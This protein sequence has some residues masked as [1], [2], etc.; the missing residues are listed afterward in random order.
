MSNLMIWPVGPPGFMAGITLQFETETSP[1]PEGEPGRGRPVRTALPRP[2]PLLCLAPDPPRGVRTDRASPTGPR[3][4]CGD[5]RHPQPPLAR[6]RRP[7]A[8]G[9]RRGARRSCG[10]PADRGQH[11]TAKPQ[12]GA[13]WVDESVG[14]PGSVYA[15]RCRRAT[16]G[17]P[18]RV[19]VAAHLQRST[20]K[21][22]RAALERLLSD[23][24]PGG[25]YLATPVPWRAGGLLHHRFT[26]TA[27]PA[28]PEPGGSTWRSAFCGTVPRVTPGGR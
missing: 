21:L 15:R 24:A 23:L 18:S 27:S 5:P 14:T 25:V 6:L 11:M 19:R 7:D 8:A 13:S 2:A 20:R 22:G 10:L 3:Q 12:V 28:R 4:R 26:L 16:D 17:H 9:R 1:S